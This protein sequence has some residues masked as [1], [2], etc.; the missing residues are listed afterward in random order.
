M[1][2]A[3][4]TIMN[5]CMFCRYQG[6]DNVKMS[7]NFWGQPS[8]KVLSTKTPSNPNGIQYVPMIWGPNY[9]HPFDLNIAKW[10]ADEYGSGTVLGFNEP[11]HLEQSNMTVR[12]LLAD[13][14]KR[15]G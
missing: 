13:R 1:C 15:C 8:S 12:P 5:G 14:R 11:D 3:A 2:R 7:D 10:G 9:L 4:F 6:K